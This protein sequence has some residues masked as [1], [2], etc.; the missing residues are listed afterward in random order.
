MAKKK[1][2]DIGHDEYYQACMAGFDKWGIG[3]YVVKRHKDKKYYVS[4]KKA[5]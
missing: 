5:A 2:K 3:G 1:L 4:K